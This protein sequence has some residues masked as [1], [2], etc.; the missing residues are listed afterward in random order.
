MSEEA[1]HAFEEYSF[2][3]TFHNRRNQ[4]GTPEPPSREPRASRRYHNNPK[5]TDPIRDI[6]VHDMQEEE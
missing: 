3:T 4:G 5:R 6:H 1:S 2:E